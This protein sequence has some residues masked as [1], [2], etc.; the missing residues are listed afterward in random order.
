[1]TEWLKPAIYIFHPF[2]PYYL[3]LAALKQC[4]FSKMPKID[5]SPRINCSPIIN[6]HDPLIEMYPPRLLL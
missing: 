6:C 5:A 1:M 3:S 2:I 4:F